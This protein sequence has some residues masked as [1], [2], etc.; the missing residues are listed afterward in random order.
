MT[1]EPLT[2][3]ATIR[4]ALLDSNT[5][6]I[7]TPDNPLNVRF[8][9]LPETIQALSVNL[10]TAGDHVLIP[11]IP[12]K[13]VKIFAF[14]MFAAAGSTSVTVTFTDSVGGTTLFAA[15]AQAANQNI[16]SFGEATSLPTFL[17]ATSAG[18]AL[19]VNLSGAAQLLVNISFWEETTP[20]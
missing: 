2:F 18:N 16:F 5:I 6:W 8:A 7:G 15:L 11:A 19:N 4:A 10:T 17:F 20:S 3:S 14:S 9:G 12:G 13:V 1:P